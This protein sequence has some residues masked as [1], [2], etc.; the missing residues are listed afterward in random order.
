M[1]TESKGSNEAIL[2]N[3]MEAI[4][5]EALRR[6]NEVTNSAGLDQL[7]ALSI[8]LAML[9]F[10]ITE[11]AAKLI[12][13]RKGLTFGSSPS[14]TEVDELTEL[15][16]PKLVD[17]IAAVVNQECRRLGIKQVLP[18]SFELSVLGRQRRGQA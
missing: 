14:K 18:A 1:P 8:R 7:K 2:Y 4:F 3:A 15:L 11:E 17:A 16:T 5:Y 12:S 6:V 10:I 13:L 9:V